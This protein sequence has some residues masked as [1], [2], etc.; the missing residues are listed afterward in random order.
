MLVW[1]KG[2]INHLDSKGNYSP[3]LNNTKL[4]QWQ[5][6]GELLHF[7]GNRPKRLIANTAPMKVETAHWNQNSPDQNGPM[8][9]KN[10]T[11]TAPANIKNG[12]IT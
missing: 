3:T 7:V 5:F 9:E 2:N 12:P 6:M 8:E 11:K 1:R 10:K 4:V